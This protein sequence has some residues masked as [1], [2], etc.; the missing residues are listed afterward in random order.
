MNKIK[1][2]WFYYD[3]WNI[4]C[5]FRLNNKFKQYNIIYRLSIY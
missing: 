1:V 4:V 5:F 3:Y 2:E